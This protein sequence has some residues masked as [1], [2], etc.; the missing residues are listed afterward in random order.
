[1]FK[2]TTNSRGNK[3]NWSSSRLVLLRVEYTNEMCMK[4]WKKKRGAQPL[5]HEQEREQQA[6]RENKEN[7]WTCNA[8]YKINKE[9]H[10]NA[11]NRRKIGKSAVV[12]VVVVAGFFSLYLV[13]DVVVVAVFVLFAFFRQFQFHFVSHF[14]Y[15]IL[16]HSHFRWFR[17]WR[18][19][20]THSH[21]HTHKCIV[22]QTRTPFVASR[23]RASYL[24]MFAVDSCF[25][26]A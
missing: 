25:S 16:L 3:K 6:E 2:C 12:V 9:G 14:C 18:H 4:I 20:N 23:E 17:I 26:L 22:K 10:R 1:M 19:T 24:S 5:K 13:F 15:C 8:Y 11:S 21:S 7:D